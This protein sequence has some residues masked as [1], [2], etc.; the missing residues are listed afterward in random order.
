MIPKV[1]KIVCPWQSGIVDT[2]IGLLRPADPIETRRRISNKPRTRQR[3]GFS[4]YPKQRASLRSEHTL[5]IE[6]DD[7]A[8]HVIVLEQIWDAVHRV[9]AK[10]PRKDEGIGTQT[11]KHAKGTIR[12]RCAVFL[13]AN[14]AKRLTVRQDAGASLDGLLVRPPL[15]RV[16]AKAEAKFRVARL[17]FCGVAEAS[18]PGAPNDDRMIDRI[19]EDRVDAASRKDIRRLTPSGRDS[20]GL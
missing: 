3:C 13:I 5:G 10:Q 1:A 12:R 18:Y 15:E 8:K 9:A 4:N 7:H 6:L 16:K 19:G 2:K 17:E 11:G 14:K 20:P